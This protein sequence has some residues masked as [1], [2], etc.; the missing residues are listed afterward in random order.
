M[1]TA[2]EALNKQRGVL[3]DPSLSNNQLDI[4]VS[5]FL[6]DVVGSNKYDID[7]AGSIIDGE[8]IRTMDGASTIT[9]T[10]NDHHRKILRSGIVGNGGDDTFPGLDINFDDLWFRLAQVSKS[11]DNLDFV[12]EDRIVA[13]LR[14]HKTPRKASRRDMTRAQFIHS[15]VREVKSTP[16]QFYSPAENVTPAIASVDTNTTSRRKKKKSGFHKKSK[17]QVKHNKANPRQI[18]VGD[19]ILS[20][21]ADM[22]ASPKVMQVAIAV[23]TQESTLNPNIGQDYKKSG[24]IGAFQQDSAPGSMWIKLGGATG[25][26]ETDT[27]A[28]ITEAI[29]KEKQFP[30]ADAAQL[31]ELIQYPGEPSPIW[32]IYS[33]TLTEWMDEAKEWVK[34]FNGGGGGSQ[35]GERRKQYYFMRGQPDG[36]KGENTW[37]A[38]NRLAQEVNWHRFVV[39]NT[40]FYV[41]DADLM[42]QKPI[43]T[44]S[45]DDPGV[46]YIDFDMD[47][48][49]PVQEATITCRAVRWAAHPG[50]VVVLEDSGPANGRWLVQEISKKLFDPTA[51]ITIRQPHGSLKEPAPGTISVSNSTPAKAGTVGKA[52]LVAGADGGQN[53]GAVT[54]QHVLRFVEL[55][56][57]ALGKTIYIT[58]GT[59]HN[60]MTTSGNVSD[61][62]SGNA[63][64][65]GSAANNFRV[66]GKGGDD[67]ARAAAEVLGIKLK[68]VTGNWVWHPWDYRGVSYRVQ[69]GW[70]EPDGSH[71]DHVHVGVEKLGTTAPLGPVW[72]AKPGH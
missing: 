20:V 51:T 27:K 54:K 55:M 42:K 40:F 22:G 39:G 61:H 70:K 67:V 57:G 66:G 13:Y 26:L 31:G 43:D 72:E 33:R 5:R 19:T 53:P 65:L 34:Q 9:V 16:I 10:V 36:P 25:N 38:S 17:L 14:Q 60:Q 6:L 52:I 32:T 12:F 58:T 68:D 7:V 21:A 45:E 18:D 44:L 1:A 56:A 28:F 23:A 37:D 29:K 30:K 11:S 35:T 3:Q 62:W 49:K 59:N 69:V 63:A 71:R 48:G 24:H 46:D 64:D 47:L 41:R 15:M 4:D 8:I 2:I 50:E